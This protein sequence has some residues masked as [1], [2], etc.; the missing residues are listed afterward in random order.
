MSKPQPLRARVTMLIDAAPG[1]I[2]TAFVEPEWLTRFW[3]SSA[4]MRLTVGQSAHWDFMVKGASVD[5]V[6]T[7]LDPDKGIT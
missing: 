1:Q 6:P 5:T 4:S 2:F 7:P 3:L